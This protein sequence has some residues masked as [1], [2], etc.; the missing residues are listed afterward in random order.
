MF[1]FSIYQD[2]SKNGKCLVGNPK[3]NNEAWK[4]FYSYIY[5]I[6]NAITSQTILEKPQLSQNKIQNHFIIEFWLQLYPETKIQ[7]NLS[8]YVICR[9][10]LLCFIASVLSSSTAYPQSD[11]FH[12]LPQELP[13]MCSYSPSHFFPQTAFQ[14]I[15]QFISCFMICRPPRVA[16]SRI[17]VAY[18]F[19][20]K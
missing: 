15:S 17:Q 2:N 19:N 14:F 3:Q 18:K 16:L 12:R 1:F 6:Y 20:N 10:K 7:K 8:F 5:L 9:A 4:F 13:L 11:F